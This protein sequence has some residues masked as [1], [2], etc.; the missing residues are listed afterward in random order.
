MFK[1]TQLIGFG[2]KGGAAPFDFSVTDTS[3]DLSVTN[4]FSFASQ[5]FG[6][7]PG[8][9]E[10]RYI[11]V[12]V[13]GVANASITINSVTIAGLAVST[14]VS[15]AATHT[16]VGIYIVEV[17]TG[18]TGTIAVTFSGSSAGCSITVARIINPGAA[19]GVDTASADHASGVL[20]LSVD[21]PTDGA[22][23]A[24]AQAE[25]ASTTTWS[26]L[27]ELLDVDHNSGEL[28][29]SA[30]GGSPGTPTAIT[31]TNADTTPTTYQGVCAS[32]GP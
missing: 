20:T 24:V 23:L 10:T 4:S 29:T 5:A 16:P 32:W 18:T 31:A 27:S 2:V 25:N 14:I 6:A 21:I 15:R 7:V 22:A 17:P 30:S 8:A 28:H 11:A 9:G 13:G 12:A 19:L 3:T 26:G 1:L